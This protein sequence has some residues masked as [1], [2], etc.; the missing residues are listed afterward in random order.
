ML[1]GDFITSTYCRHYLVLLRTSIVVHWFAVHI[2]FFIDNLT[3]SL[4]STNCWELNN[5]HITLWNVIFSIM[6]KKQC[7]GTVDA[8]G[9]CIHFLAMLNSFLRVLVRAMLNVT[10]VSTPWDVMTLLHFV[11]ISCLFFSPSPYAYGLQR[12]A[13]LHCRRKT[14]SVTTNPN[15][16]CVP[17]MGTRAS[18]CT[19]T[20]SEAKWRGISHQL[21]VNRRGPGNR[22]R[23]RPRPPLS[24]SS[25]PCTLLAA[26]GKSTSALICRVWFSHLSHPQL[27]FPSTFNLPF[28][29]S[30][31]PCLHLE[32]QSTNLLRCQAGQVKN[33]FSF[34][35]AVLLLNIYS[36][37]EYY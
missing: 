8:V 6:D 16:C 17:R 34:C 19:V 10:D 30:F 22:H 12:L 18:R 4:T 13:G 24:S 3:C 33:L 26:L 15:R 2:P 21:G 7:F 27:H 23:S 31:K 14:A 28:P 36:G 11:H 37:V 25:S 1:L 20:R 9:R 29:W 32:Y 5:G 35:P